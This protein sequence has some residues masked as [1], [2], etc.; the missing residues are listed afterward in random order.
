MRRKDK[1]M[2]DA[3]WIEKVLEE[4]EIIRIAMV[5]GDEPYLVAMN[6]AYAGGAIYL[7][8]ALEGRK[9]DA[10]RKNGRVAFQTETGV[11]LILRPEACGCTVQFKSVFGSGRAVFITERPEKIKALDAIMKKYSDRTG[12]EYPDAAL[13]KTLIIRIDIERMTGKKS[14]A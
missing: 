1:E 8:S 3:G 2:T 13:N 11:E 4:A 9:I 7:H 6:F 5:D 10:L 12:L 14:P